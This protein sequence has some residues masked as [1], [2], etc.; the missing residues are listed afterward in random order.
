[1]GLEEVSSQVVEGVIHWTVAAGAASVVVMQDRSPKRERVGER[2]IVVVVVKPLEYKS[3]GESENVMRVV[4][5][6]YLYLAS[7]CS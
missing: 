5:V 4:A 3:E 1:M 7:T 2:C 6:L